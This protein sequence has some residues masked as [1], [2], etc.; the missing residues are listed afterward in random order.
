MPAA[1]PAASATDKKSRRHRRSDPESKKRR[2]SAD[3]RAARGRRPRR[4]GGVRAE[5]GTGKR[6][7]RTDR[8]PRAD[9]RDADRRHEV[10]PVGAA[11]FA[12]QPV[13]ARS[14]QPPTNP[15]V[16][17]ADTATSP[18]PDHTGPGFAELGVAA[19]L[20][21]RLAADGITHAF[22]IQA[23]AIPD[24]IAGRDV[25]GRGRTGSGKTLGFGL[26][27]LTRLADHR[28]RTPSG[29]ILLPTRELA[30]QVAD[31]L[32]PL[33]REIGLRTVLVAGGMSYTPQ[34]RGLSAGAEIVIATP[35]RLIDLLDQGALT[36][37][38]VRIAVLD[39]ADHMADLGFLP[40]VTRILDELPRDGQRLLFSATLDRGVDGL[41]Q[42][43]LTDPSTHQVDTAGASVDTMSHYLFSVAPKDK[44][45]ITAEIA[46]RPGRTVVFARTQRGTDRIAGE[47]RDAGVL[48]GALHGG[49]SQS[50]RSRTLDAFRDGR[51]PVLV[52]TDVAARGIHVDDI[53]L[54]LQVDP[55]ADHKTYLHR[56][57]RTAR[58]GETGMVVTLML[59]DQRRQVRRLAKD[60][61]VSA[62]HLT[63]RPGEETL[64]ALT[65]SVPAT[66]ER[67]AA[68]EYERLIAPRRPAGSRGPNRRSGPR[69]RSGGPR[70][71]RPGRPGPDSRG[72]GPRKPARSADGKRNA[73][74]SGE[75][76]AYH[77]GR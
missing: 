5:D 56:A 73:A 60:A 16:G 15:E 13:E 65:G 44:R 70:G 18:T 23:A 10:E 77:S 20:A 11:G 33:A 45:T 53:S 43:Y 2:W 17:V 54:V 27:M 19:A 38:G 61:A 75:R 30:L 51:V 36:L 12:P 57:G 64:S 28:G 47:L 31:V 37:D 63:L 76:A 69:R 3:E 52:A 35:G 29:L 41:V 67:I 68:A 71:G 72:R 8:Q 59:P 6:K 49:L 24:A 34:L 42:Q 58:A 22:P 21:D 48:A 46:G 66:G 25:L 55:P 32:N 62:E 9:R 7:G 40:E 39:E 4:R 74:R 26:P 14:A 50:A 1:V